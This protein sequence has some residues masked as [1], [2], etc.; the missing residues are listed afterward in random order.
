M[1]QHLG[2]GS[3]HKVKGEGRGKKEE[4]DGTTTCCW[5]QVSCVYCSFIKLSSKT[6]IFSF[7]TFS[8][9]KRRKDLIWLKVGGYAFVLTLFP[10]IKLVV[11]TVSTKEEKPL[12]TELLGHGQAAGPQ[13]ELALCL[14][15][16]L[17]HEEGLVEVGRRARVLRSLCQ[18]QSV[19]KMA[20]FNSIGIF[21]PYT[22]KNLNVDVRLT[23]PMSMWATYEN[24]LLFAPG[25]L[26]VKRSARSLHAPTLADPAR[27][28]WPLQCSFKQVMVGWGIQKKAKG[29]K[30]SLKSIF[31]G[32]HRFVYELQD[33][34]FS[35]VCI[36]DYLRYSS[37]LLTLTISV[38]LQQVLDISHSLKH[39]LYLS[40]SDKDQVSELYNKI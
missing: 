7:K 15:G 3:E 34:D 21:M 17:L 9:L 30:K 33:V 14:P 32:M 2:R 31:F 28:R 22:E 13:G 29:K 26:G 10:R 20:H 25:T 19:S 16:Q 18:E 12:T 1:A 24:A 36:Q 27:C 5:L 11:Q 4:T 40:H 6:P 8:K 38:N 23:G 35:Y 39:W 37:S